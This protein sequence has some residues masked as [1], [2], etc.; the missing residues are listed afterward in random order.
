MFH[1]A[2]PPHPLPSGLSFVVPVY[3]SGKILPKLVSRLQP[4]LAALARPHELIL[5]ND[6]G[7]DN[8][9]DVIQELTRSHPW[10]RG[11]HMM[12][13]FGQHNAL[14]AGI[15]AARYDTVVTMDDDLQH[16]PEELPALLAGFTSGIDVLYGTP[17]QLQHGLLRDLSSAVTKIVLQRAM[18]S[19]TAR[20]V[21][22]WRV[23]RTDLRNGFANYN[24]PFVNI[25][26][27]L[28]WSSHR[29]SAMAVRHEPRESGSS[30]YSVMKLVRHALNMLTGFSVLPLQFASVVGFVFT[31]FGMGV[32]VY[33]VGRYL[34][35]G[36]GV[37]G[38]PFL[39]SIIAIFSG[40]QLFALGI[41]GEYLALIHFR[42]M[43]KP[44]YTVA[45]TTDQIPDDPA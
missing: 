23:F 22:A 14:L 29:F 4:V 30:N 42:T 31:L 24:S 27:L 6:A 37:A 15:R 40:A 41:I 17:M 18:G 39:A 3:N 26:V 13:N 33:V 32:L 25:D 35:F 19:K 20:M 38:F 9:W 7:P 43:S 16:P 45:E 28:T 12:R 1:P 34:M 8:S 2:K 21:S 10:I 11:I 5:V 36:S 44:A